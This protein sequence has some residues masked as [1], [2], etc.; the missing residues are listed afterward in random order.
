[1]TPALKTVGNSIAR[2]ALTL[3][4]SSFVIFGALYLS[5]GS[6]LAFLT[7]GRAL[8]PAQIHQIKSFYHLNQPF[9]PRYWHWLEGILHGNFGRSIIVNQSV[10]SLLSPRLAST[11]FLLLYAGLLCGIFGLV[12]GIIAAVRGGRLDAGITGVTTL[13]IATPSF[14]LAIVLISVFSVSLGWFPVFGSGSGFINRLWHLTLPAIALA[15]ASLGYMTQLTRASVRGE[16]HREHT[17]TARARGVPE[18]LVIRRHVV[19]NALIPISTL[20]GVTLAVLIAGLAVVEQAFGLNGIGSYL[21]QAVSQHDFP[22]VQAI[23]LLLVAAFV[24]TN[25]VV[26]ALYPLIDPRVRRSAAR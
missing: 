16:L 22:V 15:T 23:C 11:V 14:V 3:L 24:V 26:D 4:I 10:W 5:P 25:A 12:L 21:I 6:P 9:F 18:P 13:A 20:T 17:D 7:G 8:P 1:M 19:R 2:A